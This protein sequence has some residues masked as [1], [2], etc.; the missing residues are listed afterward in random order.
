MPLAE[1]GESM[2]FDSQA[3]AFRP[4]SKLQEKYKDFSEN[5]TKEDNSFYS[6]RTLKKLCRELISALDYLHSEL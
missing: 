1:Y 3:I 2:S 5:E 4:N 6:E